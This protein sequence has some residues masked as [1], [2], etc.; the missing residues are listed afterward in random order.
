KK[1]RAD[2]RSI[3]RLQ[4]VPRK[5]RT[6]R[7]AARTSVHYDKTD[8][9]E[10]DPKRQKERSN[11]RVAAGAP[12]SPSLREKS[13]DNDEGVPRKRKG[14]SKRR[15]Q[16]RKTRGPVE[17]QKARLQVDLTEL[18]GRLRTGKRLPKDGLIESRRWRLPSNPHRK[19]DRDIERAMLQA[20]TGPGSSDA[21]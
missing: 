6:A 15:G 19:R 9:G 13:G 16:R 17:N 4:S 10:S 12:N 11:D 20:L 21:E 8:G 3:R 7:S 2:N 18:K 14:R 5:K 1:K